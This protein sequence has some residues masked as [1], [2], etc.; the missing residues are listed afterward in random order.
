MIVATV[1]MAVAPEKR[2]QVID[3]IR[4]TLEP[5]LIQS[6]CFSC[7]MYQD[8]SDENILTYEEIWQ[9]QEMLERHLRSE[10]YENILAAI[11]LAKEPPEIR[12]NNVSH[13]SGIEVI[14]IA[15]HIEDM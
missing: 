7:R 11:D 12:F 9:S 1:R 5:T 13:S 15:R 6:G 4:P 2:Q 14:G 3:L 10:S 8:I